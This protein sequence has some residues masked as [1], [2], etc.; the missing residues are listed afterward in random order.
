M[1]K[2]TYFSRGFGRANEGALVLNVGIEKNK[3]SSK[4]VNNEMSFR[5]GGPSM[6]LTNVKFFRNEGPF[7]EVVKEVVNLEYGG[8]FFLIKL[9]VE[10]LVVEGVL[11]SNCFC[12]CNDF[13]INVHGDDWNVSKDESV[14]NKRGFEKDDDVELVAAIGN[15]VVN[16]YNTKNNVEIH[17]DRN[18]GNRDAKSIVE[19]S[20]DVLEIREVVLGNGEFIPKVNIVSDIQL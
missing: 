12:K 10:Q 16:V 7:V 5:N 8:K 17:V 15:E 20:P 11:H 1:V 4:V 13:N 3:V 9:L 6:I 2:F 14:D 19:Q 18:D